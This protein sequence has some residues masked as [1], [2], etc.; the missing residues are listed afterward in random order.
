[1]VEQYQTIYQRAVERKGSVKVLE[2]M[3]GQPRT[4]L[5]LGSTGDDRYLAE[6]TRKIFQSGFVWRVV[7]AKWPA[8]EEAFFGFDI[9]KLLMMPPEME[10]RKASDPAIIR[11]LTKVRTIRENAM[12]IKDVQQQHGSFGQ[13]VAQ[14]PKDNIIALWMYLKTHGQRLGGNTGPYALR[15]LGVDTFLLTRDVEGYFRAHGLI[16]GSATS[17]R[18]LQQIQDYFLDWQAQSGRSLTELSQLVALSS[19]DNYL[20][21]K[22]GA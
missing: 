13:F 21:S 4:P 22:K 20:P 2:A 5:Q 6:M 11:N 18:S 14:W 1:M 7:N 17:K 9:D 10:E 12:M 19:G 16:E 3:L 8:F 15:A